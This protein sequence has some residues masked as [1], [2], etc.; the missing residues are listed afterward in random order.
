MIYIQVIKKHS[1][2]PLHGLA[3]CTKPYQVDLPFLALCCF[4]HSSQL[5]VVM[6]FKNQSCINLVPF[7]LQLD[8]FVQL[9]QQGCFWRLLQTALLDPGYECGHYSCVILR[10]FSFLKLTPF[11]TSPFQTLVMKHSVVH[12]SA[13]LLT[14][15]V[16]HVIS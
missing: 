2:P 5:G 7:G 6:D 15:S 9:C 12:G 11:V 16:F 8:F 3:E 14:Q 1:G 4:L 10:N 13:Y